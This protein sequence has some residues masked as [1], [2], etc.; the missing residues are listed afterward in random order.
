MCAGNGLEFFNFFWSMGTETI[1]SIWLPLFNP[2]GFVPHPFPFQS[3]L[4]ST[5]YLFSSF[6]KASNSFLKLKIFMALKNL[7]PLFLQSDQ[8]HFCIT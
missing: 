5:V 1:L 2:K 3:G 4:G 7:M 6:T 8:T